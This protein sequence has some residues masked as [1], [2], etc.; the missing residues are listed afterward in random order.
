MTTPERPYRR[1]TLSTSDKMIGGV[2]GGIAA[3]FNVD[4]TLIRLIAVVLALLGG[5]GVLAYLLAW[6]V[7]PK[8]GPAAS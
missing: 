4:P 3:Y 8:P 7:I 5:G 1:L 6:I 2:C